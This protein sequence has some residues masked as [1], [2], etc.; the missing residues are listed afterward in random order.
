MDLSSAS[1]PPSCSGPG[2]HLFGA[3]NVQLPSVVGHGRLIPS[4]RILHSLSHL[5]EELVHRQRNR[6]QIHQC[7]EPSFELCSLQAMCLPL[8]WSFRFGAARD[9]SFGA[10]WIA[11]VVC[12]VGN[13]FAIEGSL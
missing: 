2:F 6:G 5:E 10:G 12:A 3:G 9:D 13:C 7:R 1:V 11:G 8:S 4:S